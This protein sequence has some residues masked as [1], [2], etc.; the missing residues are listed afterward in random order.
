LKGFRVTGEMAA[1][2]D[3]I[4]GLGKKQAQLLGDGLAGSACLI[5]EMGF[6]HI[7]LL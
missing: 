5:Y 4:V 3:F 7:F 6:D 2:F 1:K